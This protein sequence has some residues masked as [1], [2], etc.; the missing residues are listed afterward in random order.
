MNSTKMHNFSNVFGTVCIMSCL[1]SEVV[2]RLSH[3]VLAVAMNIKGILAFPR[4]LDELQGT[5]I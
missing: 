5:L 4:S 2:S 3:E 1:W